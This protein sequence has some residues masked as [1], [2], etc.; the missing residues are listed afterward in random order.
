[1]IGL[2]IPALLVES[3]VRFGGRIFIR[4]NGQDITFSAIARTARLVAKGLI[5]LGVQPKD[6]LALWMPNCWEWVAAAL[7]IQLAGGV[8]IP[9]NTRLRGMEVGGILRRS[10]ASGLI[11]IGVF[12]GVDFP[13]MLA[14]QDLPDLRHLIVS[15][16]YEPTS[17]GHLTWARLLEAGET[18]S[19]VECATRA[20]S[21]RADDICDIMFT[22]GTT[23][24]PKGALFTHAMTLEGARGTIELTSLVPDDRYAA[25]GPFS[26]NAAYKAGWLAALMVG[27]SMVT[28]PDLS[29]DGVARVIQQE[30][31]TIMPSP[32]TVLQGLL[33][34]PE[35]SRFDLSSLRRI[36]TGGTTVPMQLLYDLRKAFPDAVLATGYGMTE[37]C[38]SATNTL[39]TD[40]LEIIASTAGRAISGTEVRCVNVEGNDVKPGELG[41]VWIRDAKTMLGYLD[42]PEATRKSLDEEGWFHSGD[43]GIFD[44]SGNLKIVDRLSDMYITGGFNCYPAEIEKALLHIPGIAAASVVGVPDER[45]GQVGRAFII[46]LPGEEIDE[47]AILAW[48]KINIANYKIP[49]SIKFVEELPINATGKVVK[50]KL[51]SYS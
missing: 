18:I 37:V 2:T 7:G 26:H 14:S 48:C 38:G 39:P 32:P 16:N 19:D 30:K 8:L 17:T 23:G 49:K 22:S 25:F 9:L 46:R 41:E 24:E 44:I 4:D 51:R 43:L 36:T 1:M 47:A 35:F 42:N 3:E 12:L 31:I 10:K 50:S 27:A 6:R 5:A 40:T 33:A 34:H 20:A 29:P 21:V 11:S 13:G 15:G 45:L 28:M